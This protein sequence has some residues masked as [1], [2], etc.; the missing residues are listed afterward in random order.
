MRNSLSQKL[1]MKVNGYQIILSQELNETELNSHNF[2]KVG[3]FGRRM[4]KAERDELV[5]F[6]KNCELKYLKEELGNTIFPILDADELLSRVVY[7]EL[8]GDPRVLNSIDEF[9][10]PYYISQPLWMIECYPS[11]LSGLA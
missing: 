8:G 11:F 2:K 5:Y 1:N 6:S 7:E 4:I 9:C 10:T 3:F